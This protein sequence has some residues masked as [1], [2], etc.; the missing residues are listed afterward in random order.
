MRATRGALG[1]VAVVVMMAS[2]CSSGPPKAGTSATSG[3]RVL[4]GAPPTASAR[5]GHSTAPV[6]NQRINVADF[7]FSPTRL[8]IRSNTTVI[9]YQEGPSQ[10]TVTSGSDNTATGAVKADGKFTSGTLKVGS[11]FS[12]TFTQPGTYTYYCSIHPKQMSALIIVE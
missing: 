3:T 7:A 12:R 1:A 10:H 2:A 6:L 8:T 11:N 9:W 5:P 4:A